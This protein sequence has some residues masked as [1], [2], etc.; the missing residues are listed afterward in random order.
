MAKPSCECNYKLYATIQL[1]KLLDQIRS[2]S[3]TTEVLTLAFLQIK[4]SWGIMLC[5]QVSSSLRF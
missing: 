1:E 2:Y 4:V 3:E 5:C